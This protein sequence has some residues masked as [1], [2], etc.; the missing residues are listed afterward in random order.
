M[1]IDGYF[2]LARVKLIQENR[3]ILDI[4]V[5]KLLIGYGRLMLVIVEIGLFNGHFHASLNVMETLVKSRSQF[6]LW[7][8]KTRSTHRTWTASIHDGVTSTV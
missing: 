5:F 1:S 4:P 7:P 8:S 6:R 2:L 3:T